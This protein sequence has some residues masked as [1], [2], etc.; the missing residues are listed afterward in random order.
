MRTKL[1]SAA[2]TM[3]LFTGITT[4]QTKTWDFS[5]WPETAG[6]G[7]D[8]IIV[9][10]LGL[11]P[12]AT[13]TNFG[14]VEANTA[15]FDDGFTGTQRFKFNGGGSAGETFMPS[16][17]YLFIDVD[18][19]CQIK[20]WFKTASNGGTRTLFVTDGTAS[21]GS[22]TTNSGT[23]LDLAI[24]SANYTSATGG[25]L[26]IYGDQALNLYKVEVSGANVTTGVTSGI[27]S[28][29]YSTANVFAA[30]KQVFVS[31]VKSKT[32]VDVYTV[33]GALVRSFE[34]S[35]DT[36]FDSLT[37]GMYIVT[38]KSEEGQKSVKLVVQ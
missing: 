14:Q 19:D 16:Q 12:I 32:Q 35:E 5:T 4:A 31:N 25:R 28:N 9:D 10:M 18:S 13:N 24:L 33:V 26:Y 8:E 15:T 30:G 7:S 38:V 2:L 17:R 23:V 34:T 22:A 27:D 3:M 29:I 1:L 36:S 21:V 37:T 20:V 6:I 11:H